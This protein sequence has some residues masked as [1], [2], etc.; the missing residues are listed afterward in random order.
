ARR[1]GVAGPPGQR[2]GRGQFRLHADDPGLR[3]AG[4]GHQRGA[5]DAG[6]QPDRHEDHVGLRQR[7]E[8]FQG[9]GADAGDQVGL[10]GRVDVAQ[11]LAPADDL[12]VFAGLV[13]V[14]AVLNQFGAENPDG[15][16]LV[17]VVARRHHDD[18]ADAEEAAGVGQRLAVVPR[19]AG[20]DTAAFLLLRQPRDKVNAAANLEG[21]GRRVVL[22]LEEVTAAE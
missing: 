4:G 14:A 3:P 2:H 17:W 10:V 8:D 9:V 20:D 1:H 11:P 18:T 15:G 12:A 21:G 5:A 13:V 7:V 22:V 6:A 16:D 19:G